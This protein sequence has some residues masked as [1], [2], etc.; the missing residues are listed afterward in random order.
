MGGIL[1]GAASS[2]W[3]WSMEVGARRQGTWV[4]AREASATVLLFDHG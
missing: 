1:E 3:K 4:A 2:P